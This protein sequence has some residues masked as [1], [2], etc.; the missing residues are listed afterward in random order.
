[1]KPLAKKDALLEN[2][3][4][5]ENATTAHQNV[6]VAR[7][8]QPAIS[9]LKDNSSFKELVL[10]PAQAELTEITVNASLAMPLA[11]SAKMALLINAHHVQQISYS[12]E[13]HV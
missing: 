6:I 13:H 11:K 10:P 8:L 3:W 5:K 12:K 7:M 1:M 9:V 4:L 2:I